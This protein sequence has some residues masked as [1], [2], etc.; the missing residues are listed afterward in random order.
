MRE[1][2]PISSDPVD[3]VPP[4]DVT[5]FTASNGCPP[6][7]LSLVRGE[8]ERSVLSREGVEDAAHSAGPLEPVEVDGR[9]GSAAGSFRRFWLSGGPGERD[10]GRF[11]ARM[12]WERGK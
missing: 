11:G 12:P 5:S 10:E 6:L 1:R 2:L 7:P 3:P 8:R 4:S 9:P